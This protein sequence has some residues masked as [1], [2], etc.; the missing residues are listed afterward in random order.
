MTLILVTADDCGDLTV[1]ADTLFGAAGQTGSEIGPKIFP[2]HV[3]I[4]DLE[5]EGSISLPT[6]GFAFAGNTLSGQFTHALASTCLQ[7]LAGCAQ[8][9]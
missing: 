7:N 8:R 6:M 9:H 3:T 4:S 5:K 2:V 1:V